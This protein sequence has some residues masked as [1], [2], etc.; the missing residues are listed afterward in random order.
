MELFTELFLEMSFCTLTSKLMFLEVLSPD[1]VADDVAVN[2][3]L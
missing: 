1:F 2:D 3:F